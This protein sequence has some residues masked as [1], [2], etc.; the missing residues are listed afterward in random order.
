MKYRYVNT[1]YGSET[2]P[3]RCPS[4]WPSGAPRPR[5]GGTARKP[6]P[7]G[8][9]PARASRGR[10]TG[11][12]AVALSA[13]R[14]STCLRS[15]RRR[16]PRRASTPPR[17]RSV[18]RT[19]PRLTKLPPARQNQGV[20][21]LLSTH[22]GAADVARGGPSAV[23]APVAVRPAAGSAGA[24]QGV[25]AMVRAPR[26][27][28]L[29]VPR[30]L[31]NFERRGFAPAASTAA[32]PSRRYNSFSGRDGVQSA[33]ARAPQAHRAAVSA[34]FPPATAR[35]LQA[36]GDETEYVVCREKSA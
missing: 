36:E 16:R 26:A 2:S 25:P 30:G 17:R 10:V 33:R 35:Y 12:R 4:P 32:P 20:D 14:L 6:R 29:G 11:H 5:P 9:P 1:E 34:R 31:L 23:S 7:P 24:A 18:G 3:R 19:F 28:H 22:P 27:A 15:R 21:S 13:P 8:W